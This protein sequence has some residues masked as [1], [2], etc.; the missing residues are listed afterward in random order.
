[1]YSKKIHLAIS[2]IFWEG[3][4]KY[5]ACFLDESLKAQSL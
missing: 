3:R 4:L 1:M 2:L 5:Y